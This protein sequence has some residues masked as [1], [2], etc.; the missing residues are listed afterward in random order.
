VAAAERIIPSLRKTRSPADVM[1][2]VPEQELEVAAVGLPMF[3]EAS[4]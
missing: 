1:A 2:A 3:V 4:Q